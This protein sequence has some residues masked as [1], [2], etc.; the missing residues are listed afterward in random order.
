MHIRVA[1]VSSIGGMDVSAHVQHYGRKG[2]AWARWLRQRVRSSE[3]VFILLAILVG[4]GAGLL[5]ILLGLA[6]WLMQHMLFGL[7]VDLIGDRGG[8]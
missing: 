7:P 2:Y 1:N 6:A 8:S 5:T 4:M 3:I